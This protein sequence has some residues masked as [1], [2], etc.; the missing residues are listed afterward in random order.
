MLDGNNG[1]GVV[2]DGGWGVERE[3]IAKLLL[4]RRPGVRVPVDLITVLSFPGTGGLGVE[5]D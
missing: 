2:D 3:Q 5:L 1:R 4:T